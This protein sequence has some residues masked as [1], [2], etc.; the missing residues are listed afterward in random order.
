MGL[1]STSTDK[2]LT[3]TPVSSGEEDCT[4]CLRP[5]WSYG[6]ENPCAYTDEWKICRRIAPNDK[7]L[8]STTNPF[9]AAQQETIQRL[10][11]EADESFCSGIGGTAKCATFL[12]VG[13]VAL[14][15]VLNIRTYLKIA[16]L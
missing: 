3:S 13:I 15:F 7:G 10:K 5:K 11:Q 12:L 4:Y 2:P 6:S 14:G 8:P 16:A 9:E 1:F